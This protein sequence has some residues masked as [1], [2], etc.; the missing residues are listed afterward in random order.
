MHDPRIEEPL[1]DAALERAIEQALAVD[2]SPAFAARVRHRVSAE[3]AR[4]ER[5]RWIL[6]GLAACTPLLLGALYVAMPRSSGTAP[7][8]GRT[9]VLATSAAPPGVGVVMEPSAAE[10][11]AASAGE[12]RLHGR[13]NDRPVARVAQRASRDPSG[14]NGRRW[15]PDEDPPSRRTIVMPDVVVSAAEVNGVRSL[16]AARLPAREPRGVESSSEAAAAERATA[17]GDI[18]AEV[19]IAPLVIEPLELAGRLQG[20]GE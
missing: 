12:P 16:M 5:P 2:P 20:E 3:T 15:L 1:S 4:R 14:G 11:A 6:I 9:D 7:G 8:A 10:P 18:L 17:P 13:S 19:T